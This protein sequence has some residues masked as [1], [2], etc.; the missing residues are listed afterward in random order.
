MID[1]GANYSAIVNRQ[2]D[3]NMVE[4]SNALRS[5]MDGVAIFFRTERFTLLEKVPIYFN[6]IAIE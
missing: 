5:E 6:R 3:R 4:E 2:N 1:S